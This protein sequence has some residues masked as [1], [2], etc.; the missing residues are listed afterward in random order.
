MQWNWRTP[1]IAFIHVKWAAAIYWAVCLSMLAIWIWDWAALGGFAEQ[2]PILGAT[3]M[4]L[5]DPLVS[6][7]TAQDPFCLKENCI[8]YNSI[9]L[10][11]FGDYFIPTR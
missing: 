5:A 1:K 7:K 10:S 2:S 11:Q 4:T 6:L 9:Q 3:T 8:Y